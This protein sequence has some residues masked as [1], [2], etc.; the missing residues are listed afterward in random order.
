MSLSLVLFIR[1]FLNRYITVVLNMGLK[2]CMT[3]VLTMGLKGVLLL[4]LVYKY[5]MVVPIYSL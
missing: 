5:P 2:S 4:L 3:V 1:R